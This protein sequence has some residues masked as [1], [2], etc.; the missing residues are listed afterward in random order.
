MPYL[1][2]FRTRVILS[3]MAQEGQELCV[4]LSLVMRCR[5]KR[6]GLSTLTT[7]MHPVVGQRRGAALSAADD[8][9]M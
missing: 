3:G 9:L 7:S 2:Y 5:L 8:A 6:I 1:L 4:Q